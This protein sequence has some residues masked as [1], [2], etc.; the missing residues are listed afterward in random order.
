L[1]VELDGV[2][3]EGSAMLKT[4]ALCSL[5][6]LLSYA[7]DGLLSVVNPWANWFLG[8]RN[9]LVWMNVMKPP[10]PLSLGSPPQQ[11]IHNGLGWARDPKV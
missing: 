9:G 11:P 7:I 2:A 1:A 6:L 3:P 5:R 4:T 8:W 10:A